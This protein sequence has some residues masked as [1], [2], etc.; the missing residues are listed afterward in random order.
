MT[1]N[2][3]SLE[4]KINP[5]VSSIVKMAEGYSDSEIVAFF[6][7]IALELWALILAYL[8]AQE[9]NGI[10]KDFVEMVKER[11]AELEAQCE[12]VNLQ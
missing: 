9:A 11:S 4:N 7:C 6:G 12:K 8:P 10:L 3:E 2:N 1:K 5:A